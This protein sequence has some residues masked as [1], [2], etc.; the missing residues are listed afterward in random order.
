M[1]ETATKL[2][3]KTEKKV[4]PISAPAPWPAFDALR[5]EIDRLFEG[6]GGGW[7]F[8]SGRSPLDLPWP[9]ETQWRLNPAVDVAETDK[10]FEITAELPGMSEKDVEVTLADGS[11]VITG[12]KKEERE[13]KESDTYLSERRYGSFMRAFALPP[14]VEAGKIEASFAKGVLTV[15][16]PKS[17]EAPRSETKIPV[18]AA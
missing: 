18:K 11:L 3:V 6:M 10:Q 8:A 1:V 4:S 7:P 12:E 13:T 17:A 15:R 9:R 5:R 2:P 14:N 16:L